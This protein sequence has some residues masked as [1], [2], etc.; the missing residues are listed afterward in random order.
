M[1]MSMTG[2]AAVAV[3][4]FS[5]MGE[6]CSVEIEIKS[7][8]GRFFEPSCKIPG[9]LS[10]H[11]LDIVQKMKEKL[12]RG[13]V[14]F[15]VRLNGYS[16]LLESLVFSESRVKE[17]LSVEKKLKEGF[18]IDGHLSI[19][20]IIA[21]PNFFSTERKP[22]PPEAMANFLTGVDRA[23]D[24]VL[25]SRIR[26]GESL[27]QDLQ[28]RFERAESLIK[29]ISDIGQELI[30]KQKDLIAE[31]SQKAQ[32]G[33]E[34]AKA[35]LGERYSAL[36]KIDLHEEI[37]RFQSHIKAIYAH[38]KSETKEKGRRFDFI[39]QELMRETNT[40]TAKCSNYEISAHAVD[41]KVELEKAREQTQNI[42]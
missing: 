22:L 7:F 34:E 42:V 10:A 18:G 14:Y 25:A 4:L 11:E 29:K 24:Q 20:Q 12:M 3:P 19:A 40:I 13:R 39:L 28:D 2:F 6:H 36:D 30:K 16:A 8:N 33:D 5:Q 21:L 1:I 15:T 31:E 37:V 35:L 23:I 32:E 41:I 27:A 26:E 9:Y 38:I 17:Y